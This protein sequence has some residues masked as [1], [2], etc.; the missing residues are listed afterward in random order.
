MTDQSRKLESLLYSWRRLDM[1]KNETAHSKH[2]SKGLEA[3]PLVVLCLRS[4][5]K[6]LVSNSWQRIFSNADVFIC[7]ELLE[8][9]A[10]NGCLC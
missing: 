3:E 1:P 7:N 5:S 9:V 6:T 4:L 2:Q 8:Q 10:A